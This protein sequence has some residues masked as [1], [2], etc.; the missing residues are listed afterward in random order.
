MDAQ[1]QILNASIY[2][3]VSKKVEL[4]PLDNIIH[5]VKM[6]LKCNEHII[7][8][9]YHARSCRNMFSALG[10]C[11]F[12]ASQDRDSLPYKTISQKYLFTVLI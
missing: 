5:T 3:Y 2:R 12:V 11:S 8:L 1:Q 7:G 10:K 9:I 6:R 4:V